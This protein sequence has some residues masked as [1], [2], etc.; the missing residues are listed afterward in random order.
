MVVG[1]PK[2]IVT[3]EKRVSV[4]PG[5]ISRLKGIS[6]VMERGAGEAAGF[7]DTAYVE[8]GVS[9]VD[10]SAL[11]E[12]SDIILK[13]QTPTATEA[14]LFKEGTTLISFLYPLTN[15]E[16]IQILAARRVNA[17]A[18]NLIP[19]S[20]RAQSMDAL[21]SQAIISGY[22]AVLLGADSL[23]RL[24]PMLMTAAGTIP[25]AKVF[26]I[27]AG[28]AGLQAIAVARRLGTMVEAYDVRPAAKEEIKSLGA[29]FVELPIESKE[30]QAAG[31]Y[32][33]IQSE[34]FYR[35]QQELLAEHAQVSDIVITT[36]LVP[37][38]RAPILVSEDAVKKMRLGS[39]IVDL[40]AEQ[41]GNCIL[42]EPGKSV[43][44]YGITIHGLLNLP[45]TMAPQASQLYS[46][47]ITSFLLT[48]L[49]DGT[50][51]IDRKDDLIHEPLVIFD[52][53]IV[54]EPTKAAISEG[55]P[56]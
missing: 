13:I 9:I 23:P 29:T 11:Y 36:A 20:S 51:N 37:G 27:G 39:V 53:E 40:A 15:L 33:K 56:K 54:H 41:G 6:V 24:F 42:T 12:Q 28:V 45:S 16:T 7:P 31:G 18:M 14:R 43:V 3:G 38:R 32:A 44:K 34:E 35:K 30:E 50:L 46:R 52:G 21:S 19:R 49:K 25:P 5:I 10:T 1:I 8:Q 47:N 26:V 2:E 55:M 4:V 48:I 17:L 22:K